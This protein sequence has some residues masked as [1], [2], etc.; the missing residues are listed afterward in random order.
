VTKAETR[1][2]TALA[3]A[4]PTLT[5]LAGLDAATMASR[6]L[7]EAR[8]QVATVHPQPGPLVLDCGPRSAVAVPPRGQW[9]QVVLDPDTSGA[10]CGD[11]SSFAFWLR[12]APTGAPPERLLVELG[13]GA[14]CVSDALCMAAEAAGGL[15][16]GGGAPP[17]SGIGL[18]DPTLN[19]FADWTRVY[20]PQ[21]SLD[22]HTGG[23]VTDIFP[24]VTVR[25]FGARNLRAALRQVR[26]VL[27]TALDGTGGD[28]FRPDRLR[29]FFS[30]TSG[31]GYGVT[32]NYHHLL[33]DLRW[34]HTTAVADSALGLDDGIP[35]F[36][37][38]GLWLSMSNAVGPLGWGSLPYL[39]PYCR[40][41]FCAV[42]PVQQAAMASRL[43]GTPEQQMLILSSQV[44]TVQEQST[45]FFS[46]PSWITALRTAYCANQGKPGLHW[47][48]PGTTTDVHG[49]ID[50]SGRLTLVESGGTTPAAWLAGAMTTP[51][52]VVDLVEEGSIAGMNPPVSPFGCPVL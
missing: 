12:L 48:M 7:A 22:L 45:A 51:A 27:W 42:L 16:G 40:H 18:T 23:G 25:R 24:H 15:H 14:P 49:L 44:D 50:H 6:A 2:T 36:G 52:G 37:V 29:V 38:Q 10:Q 13:A 1:A 41:G 4:C 19:P 28:G 5:T 17:V 32:Y 30:G 11:G 43:L 9:V 21:C 47:F 34:V 31:G 8:C 26:D 33:D 46:L 20:I 35:N 3:A 39:A